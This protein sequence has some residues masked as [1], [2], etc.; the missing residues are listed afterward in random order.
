MNKDINNNNL[1]KSI[2]DSINADISRNKEMLSEMSKSFQFPSIAI[3]F[4]KQSERINELVKNATINLQPF[5]KQITESQEFYKKMVNSIPKI[6]IP[7][8][9]SIDIYYHNPRP[10]PVINRPELETEKSKE[11]TY[12]KAQLLEAVRELVSLEVDKKLKTECID[13]KHKFPFILPKTTNWENITIKFIDRHFVQIVADNNV[14]TADY[15]EMNFKD[16]R[17]LKPN[18]QWILL[19]G[20]SKNNGETSQNVTDFDPKIIKKKQL[21]SRGLKKY[22]GLDSDPFYS[23][24]KE[25]NYRIKINLVP[26]SESINNTR[27]NKPDESFDDPDDKLGI[28]EF[29]NDVNQP[30]YKDVDND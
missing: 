11:K 23:Y 29:L 27:L 9:P 17:R 20:L 6:E 1:S 13:T 5:L 12:T 7:Q 10:F 2:I 21:L 26:E 22:F 25:K 30:H 28:N 8:L 4:V 24:K 14:Y 16:G 18:L 19:E 15:N 3:D